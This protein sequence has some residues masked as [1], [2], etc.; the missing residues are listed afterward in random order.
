MTICGPAAGRLGLLVRARFCSGDLT[1]NPHLRISRATDRRA[2]KAP[3]RSVAST[4]CWS[5]S[6]GWAGG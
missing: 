4:D 6:L 2:R 5:A 3:A 1:L